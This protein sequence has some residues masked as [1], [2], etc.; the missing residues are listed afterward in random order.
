VKAIMGL[1][2]QCSGSITFDG[3]DLLCFEPEDRIRLGI[4]YVPQVANVFPSMTILENLLVVE[5]DGDQSARVAELC[6][7]FPILKERR[8]TRAGLLSGAER[9]RVAFARALMSL[10]LLD[11]PTASLAPNAAQE[12]FE[13]I[14]G[15]PRL[16]VAAGRKA[17]ST[18]PE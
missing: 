17:F 1:A 7:L 8:H 14:S 18:I 12:V 3:Q 6:E 11:E 10:L 5:T 13:L 16:G 4:G 2:P 9:Q 15:L